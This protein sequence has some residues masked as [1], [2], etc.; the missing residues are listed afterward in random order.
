MVATLTFEPRKDLE[1]LSR[2]AIKL[3]KLVTEGVVIFKLI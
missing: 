2:I 3:S 1:A